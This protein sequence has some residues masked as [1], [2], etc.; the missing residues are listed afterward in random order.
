MRGGK[1]DEGVS[2]G[3]FWSRND[4]HGDSQTNQVI[5]LKHFNG[6]DTWYSSA[7]TYK[8]CLIPGQN[9]LQIGILQMSH[10]SAFG[11]VCVTSK[12][13]PQI[14]KLF[15]N[16]WKSLISNLLQETKKKSWIT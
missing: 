4:A 15:E 2:V 10:V 9:A 14:L 1:G 8:L 16:K 11:V 6:K 7:K 12:G 3:G 5:K 13:N